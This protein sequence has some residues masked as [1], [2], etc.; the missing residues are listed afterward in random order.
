MMD[1]IPERETKK[2]QQ[3]AG[4]TTLVPAPGRGHVDTS[5]E[6]AA[7]H[8]AAVRQGGHAD[9]ARQVAAGDGPRFVPDA[10]RGG[11]GERRARVGA[12][13]PR[14]GGRSGAPRGVHQSLRARAERP[15]AR[16][17]P[18]RPRLS[19]A[20]GADDR[21]ALP[22]SRNRARH[23]ENRITQHRPLGASERLSL[24]VSGRGLEPHPKGRKFSVITEAR[25][26][27]ELVWEEASTY[28][29]RGS[30]SGG[31]GK[32]AVPRSE[33]LSVASEWQLPGDLG[34]R[35][36][37]VSG[38]HNPIHLH[39]LTAR[40]FGYPRPI[41]HG[42][43]VKARCLGAVATRLPHAYTAEVQFR[44]PVLL[45]ARVTFATAQQRG[46]VRFGVRDAEEGTPHLDGR[47]SRP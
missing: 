29:R 45:P 30:G 42:M 39:G 1:S 31:D 47:V 26:G 36:A 19:H 20:H 12:C 9:A 41:A 46:E 43:C 6:Q 10:L 37:A 34:R 33:N 22:V 35:Y 17:V 28:L 44:R 23:I 15:A 4:R 32:P 18:S 8:A 2:S 25:V 5:D 11:S 38:D 24:R 13:G 16:H 40:L 7:K 27:G 3:P 21:P 14:Y